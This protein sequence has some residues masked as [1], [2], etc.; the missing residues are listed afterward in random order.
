MAEKYVYKPLTH[1]NFKDFAHLYCAVYNYQ[2]SVEQIQNKFSA[3]TD[4]AGCIGYLAYSE[5]NEVAAFYGVFP[6]PIRFGLSSVIGAQSGSTMTHPS[7][8]NQG[9]FKKL[10]RLTYDESKIRKV[11]FVYGI[12]NQY[13]FKGFQSLGWSF[14]YHMTAVTL[15]LPTISFFRYMRSSKSDDYFLAPQSIEKLYI[16]KFFN[17]EEN[18]QNANKIQAG[19]ASQVIMLNE[20]KLTVKVTRLN[21]WRIGEIDIP[22]GK[23]RLTCYLTLFA[24]ISEMLLHNASLM[25]FFAQP[26]DTSLQKFFPK[27]LYRRSLQLGVLNISETLNEQEI[28]NVTI[29]YKDYDTF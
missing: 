20:I 16:F 24:L 17:R 26:H 12:P 5:Q 18:P 3:L 11:D 10:A 28:K 22:K 25:S 8:R 7:H 6:K 13:S 4:D 9:L 2:P 29:K 19:A 15:P 27:F 14:L 1:E 21:Q 23:S